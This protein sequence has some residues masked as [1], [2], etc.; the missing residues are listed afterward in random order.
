MAKETKGNWKLLTIG[1]L[2]LNRLFE[3]RQHS[4]DTLAGR[5]LNM[6]G[7][8]LNKEEVEG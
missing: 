6:L 7:K 8:A 3:S 4:E 2:E 5:K 1:V